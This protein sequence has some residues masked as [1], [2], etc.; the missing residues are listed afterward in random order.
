MVDGD[1]KELGFK[2]ILYEMD[3]DNKR[4]TVVTVEVGNFLFRIKL[5]E[6]LS[7]QGPEGSGDVVLP[8][9]GEF[10]EHLIVSH[11]HEI[12][13]SE[14]VNEVGS[15]DD[16][17]REGGDG[18]RAFRGRRGHL[19][20]LPDGQS[21]A[22]DQISRARD[23]YQIDLVRLNG[24]AKAAGKSR[25]RTFVSEAKVAISGVGPVVSRAPEATKKLHEI[26]G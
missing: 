12:C 22:P 3:R 17:D 21:P 15:V 10:I 25:K 8:L 16:G 14:K 13:C 2:S 4:E 9:A 1:I 23:E 5:N 19:R 24:E 18:R 7:F 26:L 20:W 6:D 11:L